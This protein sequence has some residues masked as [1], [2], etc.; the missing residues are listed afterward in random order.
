MP[1]RY[2]LTAS[3]GAPAWTLDSVTVSGQDTI[4]QP[5]EIRPGQHITDTVL[6]FTDRPTELSGTIVNERGEPAPDQ[7]ILLYPAEEKLWTPDSRRIRVARAD[8]DGKYIFRA[9]PPG[10][11]RLAT[12]LDVEPGAWQDPAFLEALGPASTR[13]SL[14]HGERKVHA[15]RV[16]SGS[17]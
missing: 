9:M 3:A 2:R 6:L 11:Y 10:D 1:G 16:V 5:L 8:A 7:M 14:E 17:Q 12:F 15:L 4:D 13:V